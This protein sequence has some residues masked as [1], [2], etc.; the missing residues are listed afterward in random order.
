MNEEDFDLEK[1]KKVLGAKRQFIHG[2]AAVCYGALL[3]GCNF[4]GGY[5][6]TPASEIA[7]MMARLLPKVGGRYIQ[8]EDELASMASIIGSS[9]TGAKAMTATSG[10]GFSLMQ[11]NIGFAAMSETPVVVANVQRSGP[12]TGQ[13]TLGAQGDVM[14]GKYGS[15]GDYHPIVL[16]PNTIQETV[17]LTIKSFNLAEE[18]RTPV[19]LYISADLGHMREMI[20]IPDNVDLFYRKEPKVGPD[21]YIP[22]G[23]GSYGKK[24]VPEF[25]PFGTG[26]KT[27]VTGLT[28]DEHGFPA[29]DDQEDHDKLIRRQIEKVTDDRELLTDIEE[30]NIDDADVAILSYGVASRSALGAVNL[31]RKQGKK[32][33]YFRM[34][35]LWPFPIKAVEELSQKVD[36]IVVAE[37]N[38]GQM[39][40]KVNEYAECEV[41]LAGKIG[42][43]L[44]RPDEILEVI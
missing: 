41:V 8:M 44:H 35:T 4:F 7:E 19:F 17:E 21:E 40:H 29:T 32:V 34:K 28:H 22:F 43:E 30:R 26:Y 31:A 24:K 18:Y 9:W 11:E 37:M 27:Y 13:P 42:G 16:S 10:P 38:L 25:A 12:S 15:H 14:Q 2:D 36:K 1:V 23:E 20:E 5:P 3:A 33:G 6:I 39:Y